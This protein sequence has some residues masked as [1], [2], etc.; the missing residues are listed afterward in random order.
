MKAPA[1]SAKTAIQAAHSMYIIL[2]QRLTAKQSSTHTKSQ[3]RSELSNWL[4]GAHHTRMHG[5]RHLHNGK[6]LSVLLQCI[7]QCDRG[8]V[9]PAKRS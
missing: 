1:S 3:Y 8:L 2:L 4:N 6:R 5:L 7:S 9:Q